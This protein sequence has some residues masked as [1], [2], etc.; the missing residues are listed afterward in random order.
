MTATTVDPRTELAERIARLKEQR[1]AVILAHNYQLGEVQ[2]IADFV[3]DSLELSRRATQVEADVIVFCGVMFMAETAKLLNPQRTVLI[4]DPLAGC[5]MCEMAPVEAVRKRKAELPGV[6]VVAYVNTTAAVKAEADI[7]CT[8]ANAVK[9]VNSLPDKRI[10]FLPDK[11]L[12]HWVQRHTDKEIILWD[13]YCPTHQKITARDVQRLRQEHPK[14]TVIV[15]PECTADVIDLADE[16]L[17]TGQMLRWA[18]ESEA[19]EVI[20]GTEVGLIHRLKQYNPDKTFY[21]ISF[22]STC[23]NMKR[24][25][26]EKVAW[27]LEDMQYE[28]AVPAEV[29]DK[30]R[31]AIERMLEVG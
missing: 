2:D 30:A 23:P 22:L 20:V 31:R 4:P 25:T 16:V 11:H 15:H 18:R 10:L 1:K 5:P 24:I 17:S 21:P 9:I 26:L 7:C 8:S 12:G 13:G 14:A 29:A 6:T 3:G 27:A 19:R 28:V